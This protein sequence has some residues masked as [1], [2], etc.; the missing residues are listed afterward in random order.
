MTRGQPRPKPGASWRARPERTISLCEIASASAGSSRR[1]AHEVSAEAS[2]AIAEPTRAAR[3]RQARVKR[4][5][6]VGEASSER[7]PVRP[8]SLGDVFRDARGLGLHGGDARGRWRRSFSSSIFASHSAPSAI[9]GVGD[10]LS[11]A[12]DGLVDLLE[13]AIHQLLLRHLLERL[14]VGEDES[15]VLGA[16]DPKSAWEASPMPFT[17]QPRTATS[18]G[19]S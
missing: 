14:A 16:G 10:D 4:R 6:A 9:A 8:E 3:E 18:I 1:V 2:H 12:L 7:A 11:P 17:A 15:L 5:L 19:S 13:E